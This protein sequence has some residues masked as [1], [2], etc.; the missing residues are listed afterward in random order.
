MRHTKFLRFVILIALLAIAIG[1]VQA[2]EAGKVVFPPGTTIK[3]GVATDL[4]NHIPEFGK[5]I[6]NGAQLAVNDT[7]AAGGIKGFDVELIVEDDRCEGADGTTV[8]SRMASNPEIVA[9]VGHICSA[10]T[11]AAAEVYEQ[12]RIPMMSPSA[13]NALLT[14]QGYDVFNR[15]AGSDEVQGTVD[16]HYMYEVLGFRKIAVLHDNALYGQGLSQVVDRVF[17]ELGGEVTS[18]QGIDTAAQDYRP[19]LTSLVAEAPEAIFFGGYEQQA[20]LLV[21]QKDDV[22]LQDVVF[23]S[24]DGIYGDAFITGA[25]DAAEGVYASFPFGVELTGDEAAAQQ[26]RQ[27]AFLAEYKDTFGVEPM[28]PYHFHAYDAAMLLMKAIDMVA[29]VDD[30]GNLVVDRE[31]L[32]KAVRQIKDYPG[33]TGILTCGSTGE[34]GSFIIG[35]NQVVDGEWVRLELPQ[36]LIDL[37]MPK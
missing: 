15:V 20:V 33:L 17:K 28:G 27:D 1:P 12:A 23:F 8:A 26:A 10:P 31:E 35:V 21:P 24:D 36:D 30:S 22:G 37:Q 5:D 7:N 3:L 32:I 11:I 29:V 16:A 6:A 25:G 2:Q 18:V 34:C 9:V 4:T 13:T 19:V 14:S